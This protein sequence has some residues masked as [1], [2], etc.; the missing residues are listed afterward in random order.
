MQDV[1]EIITNGAYS[2]MDRKLV[3]LF[4]L[5]QNSV[6]CVVLDTMHLQRS[7]TKLLKSK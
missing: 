5:D 4:P 1:T 7:E 2:W 3:S 6:L